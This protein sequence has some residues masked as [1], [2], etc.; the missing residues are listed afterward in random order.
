[1]TFG[2]YNRIN[3]GWLYL[4]FFGGGKHEIGMVGGVEG[5]HVIAVGRGQTDYA[6]NQGHK[7]NAEACEFFKCLCVVHPVGH[8]PFSM[9]FH[10]VTACCFN[11]SCVPVLC[12]TVTPGRQ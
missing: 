3:Q 9:F 4:V 5:F 12:K 1:M 11:S 2:V 7:E 10:R 6:A 8:H